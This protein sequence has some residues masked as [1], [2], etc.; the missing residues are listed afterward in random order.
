MSRCRLAKRSGLVLVIAAAIAWGSAWVWHQSATQFWRWDHTSGDYTD[1]YLYL[2][3]TGLDAGWVRFCQPVGS[4]EVDIA[5]PAD[6]DPQRQRRRELL[7]PSIWWDCEAGAL[8]MP[9]WLVLFV[10]A[11]PTAFLWWCDRARPRRGYCRCGYDLTGNISGRCPECGAPI[12]VER[13]SP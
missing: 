10:F 2:Q 12:Q 8:H 3:E 4:W 9:P 11:A 13:L 6:W 5:V 1:F 7:V